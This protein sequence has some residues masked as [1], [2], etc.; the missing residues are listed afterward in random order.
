M[1]KYKFIDLF[2]GAG[3]FSCGLE[4]AGH[5][6]VLGVDFYKDAIETFKANH[7]NAKTYCGD[8]K[9]LDSDKLKKLININEVDLIVGGPPC[10]G[11]STVGKGLVNDERNQL[12]REFVRIVSE[13]KPKIIILENVTG[14]MAKKNL[15]IKDAII[16]EFSKLGYNMDVKVLSASDYG[17]P[18]KRQRTIFIGVLNGKPIF[19]N[20]THG[21]KLNPF[22]TVQEAFDEIPNDALNHEKNKVQLTN[23]MDIER[24]K[25]IPAG[26]GIRYQKD[27]LMYLPQHLR[28]N[29]DWESLK[30]NRF[31]QTKLQRLPL[32]AP[33]PTILT[34]KTTY[35][36]P[37]EPRYLTA[38]EAAQCQSFPL[39]FE[40]KGSLNS[41]FKQI[42]NAVPPLLAKAL[43][44]A[45]SK[46]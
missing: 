30:E 11:M 4:M 16:E 14:M 37:I 44:K 32:D 42:G 33:S 24:L 2:S 9:L 34:Q 45:I 27:E 22:K 28:F 35:Y 29:I 15:V 39:N 20:P 36:H 38:R 40:F 1:K 6:C 26:K 19:P 46:I 7:K 8:I 31:R 3:G 13:V 23:E 17:V 43:G 10:Q 18:E 12:F 41:Q 25:C 5:E 21:N